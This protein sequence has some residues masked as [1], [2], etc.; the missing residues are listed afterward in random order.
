MSARCG[1][2]EI[3]PDEA[4]DDGAANADAP[5]ACRTNCLTPACG[6]GIVDAG[7][8]CDDGARVGGDGCDDRCVVETGALEV[9]PND[10]VAT[11]NAG[12]ER[13]HGS[14]SDKDD[15][16]WS[17]DVPVC[18]ALA[19]SQVEPCATAL[20]MSLHDPAGSLVAVGAP[21]AGGC[22]VLDP[23]D[24]PGARWVEGGGYT[25]CVRAVEGT[26][27]A[28]TLGLATLDSSSLDAETGADI[29]GDGTPDGCDV[30]RDGDGVEDTEDNCPEVSNGPDTQLTLSASGYVR[31]WLAAGPFTG[32][33]STESCRPAE[34]ARVGEDG[35]FAPSIGDAA[36][37]TTWAAHLLLQESLDFTTDYATVSAPREAYALVYLWSEA[38]RDAT[39]A[40]GADDGVFAWWNQAQVLDV[41]SCQ[42]VVADQF[43]AP[44]TVLPGWN[45]LL[46]KVR[47]Q[48]GGWGLM[49]RL[50]DGSGAALT[51]LSPGLDPLGAWRPDQTDSDGDG[52]GDVCDED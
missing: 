2:G 1:D 51:D 24:Q 15:D 36:G 38:G 32:D 7:E 26:V 49:A 6:D 17:I 28:Y 27:A 18:G 29:D 13:V 39:L 9:E 30:D 48:G 35:D 16:C 44:V 50:L 21:G 23:E 19:V 45:T 46:L 3:D 14:L 4:C 25:V 43:Q 52:R 47:D 34:V 5:D 11:A 41:S 22:A 8:E 20:T 40:V 33:A 10:D 42:G 12:A 37:D 31:T